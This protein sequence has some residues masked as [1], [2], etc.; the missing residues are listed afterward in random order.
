MKAIAVTAGALALSA[1]AANA[2]PMPQPKPPGPG[3][4]CTAT[5]RRA[6]LCPRSG[7]AGRHCQAGEWIL[8]MGLDRERLVLPCA[9]GQRECAMSELMAALEICEMLP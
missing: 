9:A 6:R 4:S 1:I 2:E 3:G 5:R 7:R 8:P